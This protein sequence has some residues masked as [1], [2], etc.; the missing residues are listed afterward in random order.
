LVNGKIVNKSGQYLLEAGESI[1]FRTPGGGGAGPAEERD[2][3]LVARDVREG[4]VSAERAELDYG[5]SEKA[6]AAE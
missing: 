1:T 3:D 6:D 5:G 2:R 4:Y